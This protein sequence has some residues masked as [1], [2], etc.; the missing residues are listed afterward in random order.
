MPDPMRTIGKAEIRKDAREKVTGAA[1]FTADVPI[2]GESQG[3]LV[4]SPHHHARIIHVEKEAA[5][6]APGVLKV[7]TAEDIPGSRLF[8]Y[9]G[10]LDQPV[11]AARVVRHRG[12]PVAFVIAR[13]RSAARHALGLVRV[14]Y[15][16]LEPVFD[17]QVAASPGA[18]LVHAEGNVLASFAIDDGDL[19]AGFQ[20]AEVVLEETF[21]TPRVAPAYLEPENA[22]AR[23]NKDGSVTVWVSSQHPFLDQAQ[24]A[25]VLGLPLEQVQVKSAFIGGA[26]GGKEDSSLAILAALGAWA[27]HGAVRLV[28]NRQES[29]LAHPKRHP[30]KFYYRLGAKRDGTLVALDARACLD[31]GAYASYG[32]AVGSLLTEMMAGSYRVP[33]VRLRTQVV[34]TNGPTCGAMR[35]FGSPQ[36]H[37]AVESMID[38]LAAKLGMDP[39]ELRRKNMLFPGDRLSTGVVIDETAASLPLLLQH[40]E[41]AQKRLTE[42]QPS[43]GRVSGVGM[44]LGMQSMG[45]GAKVAGRVHPAPGLAARRPCKT[46]P[47]FSRPGAGTGRSL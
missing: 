27:I 29:F 46:L 18:P 43:P 23:W 28:N 35:G 41:T 37:F 44:A 47:W 3:L 34:Y 17:P 9:L 38:M 36:A 24:I 11:L 1:R 15:E 13:T 39:I 12:E 5:E 19:E 40:A 31:T 10:V 45:L 26:F 16:V 30:V 4:R 21:S 14:N 22:A 7:L 6:R 2:P 42:I 8:G 25:S 32:P 20:Q 33:N